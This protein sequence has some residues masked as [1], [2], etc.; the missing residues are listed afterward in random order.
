MFADAF[1]GQE[2]EDK[3]SSVASGGQFDLQRIM[4]LVEKR[5][6]TTVIRY[7]GTLL[8][9]SR[10]KDLCSLTIFAFAHF[11]FGH[12]NKQMVF[13]DIQGTSESL[14]FLNVLTVIIQV[15]PHQ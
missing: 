5:R 9:P 1:L 12:S 7:S 10:K 3:L 2:E 4:W 15:R 6:A 14:R 8:H 13:A 11:V